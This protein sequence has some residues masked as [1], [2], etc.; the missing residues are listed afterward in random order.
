[1]NDFQ[2]FELRRYQI[3]EGERQ[4]FATYFE[5]YSPEAIQQSGAIV[6]GAFLERRD[7][8]AFT[9]IRGYRDMDD[10]AKLNAALYYGPVWK[11]HRA[12]MNGLMTHSDNVLLL[13]PF[14]PHRGI[15]ILPAVDPVQEPGGASGIVVARMFPVKNNGIDEF[16]RRAEPVFSGFPGAAAREAGLLVTLDMPNNFPQHPIRTDGPWLVW[17][18]I[19]RDNESFESGFRDAAEAASQRLFATGLLRSE[20]ELIV[21][22]PAPRSRM[23]WLPTWQ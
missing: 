7:R 5:S 6:A 21:L 16:A 20:T 23:R 13:R 12:T 1:M 15:D 3:R 14:N 2:V 4:H 19:L 17:L 11:E 9:W 18:G 8:S 10:R 22:D